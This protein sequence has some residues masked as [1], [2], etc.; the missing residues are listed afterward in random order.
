[1]FKELLEY[2]LNM[3]RPI[4]QQPFPQN[5]SYQQSHQTHRPDISRPPFLQQ[6]FSPRFKTP[7][8]RFPPSGS[9]YQSPQE[10][11]DHPGSPNR[12]PV[13]P[14][15]FYQPSNLN[16]NQVPK[17]PFQPPVQ[18][19]NT[20]PKPP[21]QLPPIPNFKTP[22]PPVDPSFNQSLVTSFRTPG[23]SYKPFIQNFNQPPVAQNY[24]QPPIQNFNHH[25]PPIQNFNQPPPPPPPIQNY[26][27]PL[28]QNFNNPPPMQNF[29]QPPPV[30]N[31]NQSVNPAY[32]TLNQSEHQPVCS[33]HQS[34][35]PAYGPSPNV[36][37]CQPQVHGAE[38]LKPPHNLSIDQC[39]QQ[40][41]ITFNIPRHEFQQ[42]LPFRPPGPHRFPFNNQQPRYQQL[43]HG[44]IRFQFH[45]RLQYQNYRSRGPPPNINNQ[46]KCN[47]VLQ[48]DKSQVA[49]DLDDCD[50]VGHASAVKEHQNMHHRLGLHKKVLYSNN[51]DAIKNWIQERKK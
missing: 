47:N 20:T 25:P 31:Y 50:F 37:Y 4:S 49:C 7:P 27:Q 5:V 1:M 22:P 14:Q 29:N 10:Y 45:P 41:Q 46:F 32:K 3:Y 2:I 26:N 24:G 43:Q 13:Q 8:Q 38:P 21:H 48:K 9:F 30:Q 39:Y 18:N 40:Q 33:P 19:F 11:H 36:P 51:S 34:P 44:N 17:P 42:R 12:G 35:N 23:H 16:I 15:G 6:Q 28:V